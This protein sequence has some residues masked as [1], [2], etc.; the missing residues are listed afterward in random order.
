MNKTIMFSIILLCCLLGCVHRLQIDQLPPGSEDFSPSAVGVVIPATLKAVELRVNGSDV[1]PDPEF[2]KFV[3]GKLRRTHVFSEV[4]LPED[5]SKTK[6]REKAVRLRLFVDSRVDTHETA[7][8]LKFVATCAS[9]FLL[10]P[11]LALTDDFDTTIQLKIVRFDG[12]EKYY[13]TGMKGTN[14]YSI[15]NTSKS[16]KEVRREVIEKTVNALMK[17]LIDDIDFFATKA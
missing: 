10:S 1:D 8:L 16:R 7:T 4:N 5:M 11:V 15:F 12:E 2:V 9:L 6:G 14:Q 17:Q 3:L 13:N